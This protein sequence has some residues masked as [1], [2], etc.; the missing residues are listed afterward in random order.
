MK[1][2]KDILS[3]FSTWNYWKDKTFEL[4]FRV[5]AHVEFKTSNSVLLFQAVKEPASIY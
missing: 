1:A 2:H 5:K 3:S 4:T